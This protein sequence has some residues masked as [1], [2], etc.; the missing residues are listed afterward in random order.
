MK[1]IVIGDNLYW[2]WGTMAMVM[3][4]AVTIVSS[5]LLWIS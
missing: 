3:P 1:V 2:E 4:N 5:S